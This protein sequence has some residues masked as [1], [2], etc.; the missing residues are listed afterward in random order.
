YGHE[1]GK[2]MYA[3]KPEHGKWQL[4]MF[5]LDWLMLAAPGHVASYV[6]STAPLFNS[7]DPTI[8]RMFNHP[9][10]RRAYFRAIQ[11]AVDSAFVQTRYEALMDAKYSSLVA[12]GIVWCDGQALANPSAVKTWFSQRR[13]F[14]VAQLSALAANFAIT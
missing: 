1:I 9:P 4:Y 6:A 3:Y 14:M 7:E 12:N 5:D 8:A 2:N 13:A 10:F 11:D